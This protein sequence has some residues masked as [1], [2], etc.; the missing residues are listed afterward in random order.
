MRFYANPFMHAFIVL[1]AVGTAQAEPL[2]GTFTGTILSSS[3]PSIVGD[4]ATGT[5]SINPLSCMLGTA[6][7]TNGFGACD[8]A[9]GVRVTISENQM[10]YGFPLGGGSSPANPVADSFVGLTANANSL[11]AE[12]ENVLGGPVS[13]SRN[14]AYVT[15]NG[16]PGAFGIGQDYSTLQPGAVS[17]GTA[18]YTTPLF[19]FNVAISSVRFDQTASL[20]PEPNSSALLLGGLTLVFALSTIRRAWQ[21]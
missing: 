6:S 20:V 8:S 10:T 3:M 19:Y 1:L 2:S 11:V 18:Y 12:V 17:S 5:F 13:S 9:G 4:P 15:F 21:T 7:S 14:F 16:A